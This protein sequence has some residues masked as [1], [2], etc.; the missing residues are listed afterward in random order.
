MNTTLS[1]L[2][3]S[4]HQ[5]DLDEWR[6]SLVVDDFSGYKQLMGDSP[7]QITEVGCW[8][9]TRRKFHGL[10]LPNQSQIAEQAV[11]QMAQIYAVER[12][13]K[14]LNAEVRL[15]I[16]QEKSQPLVQTLYDWLMQSR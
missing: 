9:H 1:N 12:E 4:H 11:R 5:G 15:R 14:E 7:D 2:F 6:G 13:V 10:Q 8:A 16:W 3:H